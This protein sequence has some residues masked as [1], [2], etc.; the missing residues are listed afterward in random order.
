[1]T[2]GLP[3]GKRELKGKELK[4]FEL[5]HET[6]IAQLLHSCLFWGREGS[7]DQTAMEYA[8]LRAGKLISVPQD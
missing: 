3:V 4:I 2:M 8:R 1:M 6:S 5:I 7:L